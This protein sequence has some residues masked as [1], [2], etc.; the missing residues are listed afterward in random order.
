MGKVGAYLSIDREEPNE[1]QP[2]DR[3]AHSKEFVHRLNVVQLEAQSARCMSCGVPFCHTGCP[4]GN[5]IPVFNDLVS[6]GRIEAALEILHTTNNFPEFTGRICPA[7]CEASCVLNINKDPVA[8]ES[9]EKEL[10]ELGWDR[11]YIVPMGPAQ[12][13]GKRVAIV[14]SGPAGLA[15]AQQLRRAGHQVVVFERDEV[16]GGLLRLGIPDFKLGKDVVE[17]R[18]DQL[19]AEGITFRTG[20]AVGQ[21]VLLDDLRRDFDAVVLAVGATMP[22]DLLIEGRQLAGIYPAMTFLAAQ[23]RA[24]ANGTANEYDVRGK[25]VLILGGGDT[26]S[27][28]LGTSLRLGASSVT[29]LELFPKPAD[30]D[31]SAWPLWPRIFRTSSSQ[32]EGGERLFGKQTLRFVGQE[33]VSGIEVQSVELKDGKL[34]ATSETPEVI[35]A[36]VVLLAMGFESADLSVFRNAAIVEMNQGKIGLRNGF[37]TNLP[38]VFS[39][40]DARRGQSLVVWA[41][42]EGR[43]AAREVDLFL[44]GQTALPSSPLIGMPTG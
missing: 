6:Q 38:N 8:I 7:P 24:I 25:H 2:H 5:D 26:G 21:D 30:A 10:A 33:K 37:G 15:C 14:G 3:V 32:E 44:N 39:C 19:R 9:I 16:P 13:T 36:E 12:S 22:R 31:P 27:D 34:L 35:A 17:R 1:D 11:G 4:L 42:W 29:Q 18:I 43:E 41:I 20:T 40:G 28:C 23:N